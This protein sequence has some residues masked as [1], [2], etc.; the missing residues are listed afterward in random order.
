MHIKEREQEISA[1]GTEKCSAHGS[2]GEKKGGPGDHTSGLVAR[3]LF[4]NDT[5]RVAF[6]LST[7]NFQISG[8]LDM[9]AEREG[10]F[11]PCTLSDKAFLRAWY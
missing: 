7:L 11:G 4:L 8:L 6:S 9:K 2:T 1:E 10:N 3:E 5:P